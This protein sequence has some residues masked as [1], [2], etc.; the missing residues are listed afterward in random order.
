MSVQAYQRTVEAN[1]SP[2]QNEERALRLA[3]QKLL[4]AVRTG[5]RGAQLV[6]ALHFNRELWRIFADD[7]STAGNGLTNETRAGIISLSLF[8]SSFSSEI[9]A[10]RESVD[11]L[12]DI[13]NSVM[14]GLATSK[15]S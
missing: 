6:E 7:C 13:N 3:N 1:A 9:A 12:I 10:G 14:I 8:V 11:A 2:R 5:S 4:E 15:R